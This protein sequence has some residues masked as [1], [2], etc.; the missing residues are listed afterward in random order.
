MTGGFFRAQH[1]GF[2]DDQLHPSERLC[3]TLVRGIRLAD[4]KR[5]DWWPERDRGGNQ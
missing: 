4:V 3:P 1:S 2:G 5:L